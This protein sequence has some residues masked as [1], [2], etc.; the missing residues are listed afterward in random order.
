MLP[1]I[2]G[3]PLTLVRCIDGTGKSCFYQKHKNAMLPADIGS[4]EIVDKKTGAPEPYITLSTSKALVELAQLG[5]LELH[6]WGSRNTDI[7]KP[8][9]MVFDLDPDAAIDWRTLAAAAAEVRER[10]KKLGLEEFSEDDRGHGLH[11]VAPIRPTNS[12]P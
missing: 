1:Y 2:E 8:D 4:I 7:E 5:V 10:L 12:W 11:V 9:R 3:R 6:P